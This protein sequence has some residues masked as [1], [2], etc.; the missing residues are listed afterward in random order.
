MRQ[1]WKPAQQRKAWPGFLSM[2]VSGHLLQVFFHPSRWTQYICDTV[3]YK[4]YLVFIPIPGTEI[5]K[6]LKFPKWE[7]G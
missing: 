2:R 5:L 6:P 4:T 1:N 3:T 7:G